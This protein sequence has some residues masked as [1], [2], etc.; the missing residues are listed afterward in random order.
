ME[1]RKISE[2]LNAG[3]PPSV[4]PTSTAHSTTD[5]GSPRSFGRW[6]AGNAVTIVILAAMVVLV[7]R[8]FDWEGRLALLIAA[9][10]VSFLIFI[11]ELGHFLVAKWCDVNVSVFSIGFGPTIPGC[12]FQWGET[13]YRVGLIPLGGYVQMLGQVDGDESSDGSDD[14]PRSYRNKTVPQRMA[15]ISAGVIMNAIMAVICFVAVY[16]GPGRDRPAAIVDTVDPSGPAFK[17]GIPTGAI[18]DRI[19]FV[20]KPNFEDVKMSVMASTSGE[21]LDFHYHVPNGSVVKTTLIPRK[22]ATDKYP[23]LGLANARRTQFVGKY[24]KESTF[25]NIGPFLPTTPAAEAGFKFGDRIVAMS[26]VDDPSKVTDLPVDP[27]ASELSQKDYFEFE[28]RLLD[29]AEKDIVLRVERSSRPA[30]DGSG[31]KVET[32]DVKV[33]AIGAL[34][35]GAQMQMGEVTALREGSDA[36]SKLV[37]ADANT[38]T[39][40]DLI[41][42]VIV[43]DPKTGHDIKLEGKTLDPELLPL[44]LRRWAKE[45]RKEKPNDPPTVTLMVRRD[46]AKPGQQFETIPIEMRW[47]SAWEYSAI[48]PINAGAPM[49]IPEL[50]LAY[51]ISTVVAGIRPGY[52]KVSPL[53]PNDVIKNLWMTYEK[54]QLFRPA[55]KDRAIPE[56]RW[57]DIAYMHFHTTVAVKT[58][59]VKVKRGDA[60]VELE[61]PAKR[62]PNYGL[63]DRGWL[64]ASDVRKQKAENTFQAIEFGFRD[65]HNNMMQIFQSLRGVA[66]GR[67]SAENFGGPIMI[68]MV[69]YRFAFLGFW[70]FLFLLG[71]ISINLAVV[72]FLPIPIL[73]GGHM[74]FLIYEAIVRK[75]ASET[76]RVIATYA[77]LFLILGMI[78][79][80]TW[81]DVVRIFF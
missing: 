29:L 5:D 31:E 39:Q 60:E 32:L 35:L 57:A 71:M 36:G 53:Q 28:R 47:D 50:G 37:I 4:P 27:R 41:L 9:I 20:D 67:I 46:R 26:S 21:S 23:M 7:L 61:M 10:G 30:G 12:S 56:N 54:D 3:N 44:Q 68:G 22:T 8:N 81:Q 65:T 52:E 34:T 48:R 79:F 2:S 73:D 25:P 11:H 76:I 18:I 75:P 43:K 51:Q 17:A 45:W 38:K 77:G 64:L 6:L 55:W 74:V 15:I 40:G 80:V 1:E 42:G 14:D 63:A 78:V 16:Q 69:A 49:P 70:E 58:V 19:G 24:E 72:N 59:H 62:D 13:T 33:P 66:S